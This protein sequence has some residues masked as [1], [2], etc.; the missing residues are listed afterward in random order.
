MDGLKQVHLTFTIADSEKILQAA[1]DRGLKADSLRGAI[2][3]ILDG[4]TNGVVTT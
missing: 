3:G 4:V 2:I 1:R